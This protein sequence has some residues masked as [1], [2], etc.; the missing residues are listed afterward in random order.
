M[1]GSDANSPGFPGPPESSKPAAALS[2]LVRRSAFGRRLADLWNPPDLPAPGSKQRIERIDQRE[3]L[4]GAAL[5]VLQFVLAIVSYL[6][7]KHSHLAKD[8]S[9]A[10]TVLVAELIGALIL[11]AG[12]LSRRRALLGFASLL[13]GLELLSFGSISAV[14]F[15]FFGGWLIFRV[16]KAQRQQQKERMAARQAE[17]AGSRST[18]RSSG[19]SATP[20]A[21]KRYTP[22]R[23][24]AGRGTS[25]RRR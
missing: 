8:R 21:T 6:E 20:V 22:P 19:T 12:T 3:R 10:G 24:P 15:L 14:L 5:S 17:R 13:V 16:Q 18:R 25:A 2:A 1:T 7:F 4:F 9:L 11:V 23:R